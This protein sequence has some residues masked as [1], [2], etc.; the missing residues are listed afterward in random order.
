LSRYRCITRLSDPRTTQGTRLFKRTSHV[1]GRR[2]RR[3]VTLLSACERYL[4]YD[5]TYARTCNVGISRHEQL[6]PEQLLPLTSL[7][8]QHHVVVLVLIDSCVCVLSSWHSRKTTS[9]QRG[10]TGWT[11]NQSDVVF[12]PS[13][14][15]CLSLRGPSPVCS[16]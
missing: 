8:L 3:A 16:N 10:T 5:G 1:Q 15:S 6:F 7:R 9:H 2:N 13:L 14:Q 4:L 12:Y 11:D